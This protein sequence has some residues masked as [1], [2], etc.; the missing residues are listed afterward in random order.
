MHHRHGDDRTRT[1]SGEDRQPSQRA[2]QAIAAAAERSR[3]QAGGPSAWGALGDTAPIRAH[4]LRLVRTPSPLRDAS[5]QPNLAPTVRTVDRLHQPDGRPPRSVD[6]RRRLLIG[7]VLVV[8]VALVGVCGA[9]A[10]SLANRGGGTAAVPSTSATTV[11]T[12]PARTVHHRAAASASPTTSPPASTPRTSAPPSA[13]GSATNAPVLAAL[14]PS[15]GVAGQTVTISGSN[16]LSADGTI[17]ASFGGQLA[18]IDCPNQD[19]C[20]VTVPTAPAGPPGQ[21]PVTVTTP[22]GASNSLTF[23][24]G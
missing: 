6:G 16:F 19:T 24:Y 4:T 7:L 10:I 11:A 13:A 23:T 22:T 8:A 9:L 18:P 3:Q 17:Q 15:T 2:L 12:S 20:T 21:V 1:G 14:D 5:A